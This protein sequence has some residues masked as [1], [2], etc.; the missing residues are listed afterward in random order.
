MTWQETNR[1]NTIFFKKDSRKKKIDLILPIVFAITP[2]D[3][4]RYRVID[5]SILPELFSSVSKLSSCI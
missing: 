1:P 5:S 4:S 2:I 3:G